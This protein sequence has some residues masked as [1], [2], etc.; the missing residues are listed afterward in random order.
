MRLGRTVAE[1]MRTMSA[2]ELNEWL[3]FDRISPIGDERAD[4]LMGIQTATM[5]NMQPRDKKN[6]KPFRPIDFMPFVEDHLRKQKTSAD[7]RKAFMQ[8]E[9]KVK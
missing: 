2:H 9:K 1:L 4:L 3:A 5:V 8:F 6:T 7:I